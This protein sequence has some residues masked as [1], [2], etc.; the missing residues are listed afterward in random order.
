MIK[1]IIFDLDN[2]L[3][4]W[5][6]EYLEAIKTAIKEYKIVDDYKYLSALIDEYDNEFRYYDKKLMVDFINKHIKSKITI[7]F[8][9]R[10]LNLF[11]SMSD[12]SIEVIDILEYLSKK[13]ELVVLTNWF[14]EPQCNRLKKAKIYKYF[15]EVIGGEEYM[16]P[17][18]K[19][20]KKA[21]G[22]NKI[23]ECLMI[24]DD[25]N[26]DIKGA[27]EVGLSVIYFNYKKNDN[28]L[29]VKEIKEFKKLK[30]VL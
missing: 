29:Q 15:K 26:K 19:A 3:I 17:D 13:Y 2:T 9:D 10:F 28:P 18:K 11:G 16:K 12:K 24:G 23:S 22:S 6:D 27:L 8:L 21:C 25:Y 5:K 1:R 20:F 4:M 7:E 14:K 30:E